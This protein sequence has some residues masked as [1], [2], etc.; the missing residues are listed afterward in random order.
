MNCQINDL[1]FIASLTDAVNSKIS[2]IDLLNSDLFFNG[3]EDGGLEDGVSGNEGKAIKFWAKDS[4]HFYAG[5]DL[6]EKDR[7]IYNQCF[8]EVIKKIKNLKSI[9]H[10]FIFWINPGYDIPWHKDEEDPT[11]R[12]IIG[13]NE[14]GGD[15]A[16]K[17]DK[18]PPLRLKKNQYIELD[19][20]STSHGGWNRTD[21]VWNL[22]VLCF[23]KS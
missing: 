17:I 23:N 19:A 9:S 16:L 20:Q 1:E 2:S 6:P 18:L 22:L 14:P 21:N 15:Y 7:I 5:K 11:L 3:S 10:G 12:V 8:D 4:E 13:L